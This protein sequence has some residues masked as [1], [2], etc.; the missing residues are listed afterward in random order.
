MAKTEK[1]LYDLE[2]ALFFEKRGA[3]KIRTGFHKK[4]KKTFV[5]FRYDE[6]MKLIYEEWNLSCKQYK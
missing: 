5:V 4:T 6:K 1:Y 2:M 3:F